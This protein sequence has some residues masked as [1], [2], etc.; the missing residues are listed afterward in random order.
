MEGSPRQRE[1]QF[2]PATPPDPLRHVRAGPA[3]TGGK[4]MRILETAA[5]AAAAAGIH[6]EHCF[7]RVLSC[8]PGRIASQGPGR[9]PGR[10]AIDRRAAAR[11]PAKELSQRPRAKWK[12]PAHT[13]KLNGRGR[14]A[15]QG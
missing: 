5:N 13:Q 8:P 1:P 4:R 6:P 9:C 11:D 10:S 14:P 2:G 15:P 3:L 7:E 12:G